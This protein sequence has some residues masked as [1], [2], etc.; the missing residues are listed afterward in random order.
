MSQRDKLIE[1][2]KNAKTADF[3]DIDLLLRQLGF[4]SRNKGT[5][6]YTYTN[7]PYVIGIVK[8]GQQVKRVYLENVKDL[9]ERMGL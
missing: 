2:I 3:N 6:H 4:K 8:H 7:A 9:L 5:S 1:K